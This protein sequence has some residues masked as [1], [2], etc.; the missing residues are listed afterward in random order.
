MKSLQ[1]SNTASWGQDFEL[2][3]QRTALLSLARFRCVKCS[4]IAGINI[5]ES[6]KEELCGKTCKGSRQNMVT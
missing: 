3:G 2:S 6:K 4:F 5:F 1:S